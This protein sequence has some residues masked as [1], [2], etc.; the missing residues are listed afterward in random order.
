MLVSTAYADTMPVAPND[1]DENRAKN[2]RVE[3][4]ILREPVQ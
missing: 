1:S 3:I 4:V 2:R